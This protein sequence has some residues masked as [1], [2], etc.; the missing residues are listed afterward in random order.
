MFWQCYGEIDNSCLCP[1]VVLLHEGLM[2]VYFG[3]FGRFQSHGCRRWRC[4]WWQW[5]NGQI[6]HKEHKCHKTVKQ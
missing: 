4:R 6:K 1:A 3:Q 5:I 2:L